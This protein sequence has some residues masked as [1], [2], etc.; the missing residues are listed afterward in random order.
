[1][2]SRL[3]YPSLYGSMFPAPRKQEEFTGDHS[4]C[5]KTQKPWAS[6]PYLGREEVEEVTLPKSLDWSKRLGAVSTERVP[7]D[8]E[9][10]RND[11][12]MTW[13]VDQVTKA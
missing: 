13:K 5:L 7:K 12:G 11:V 3:L 4:E 9:G 1:M 10:S 8:D 6:L 2:W